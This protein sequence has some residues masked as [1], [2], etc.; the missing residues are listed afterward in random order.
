M[1]DNGLYRTYSKTEWSPEFSGYGGASM[2]KMASAAS[3]ETDAVGAGLFDWMK[4]GSRD[5]VF[6]FGVPEVK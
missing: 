6:F 2:R 1:Q 3:D 5:E 4:R